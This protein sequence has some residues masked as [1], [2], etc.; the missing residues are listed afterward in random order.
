MARITDLPNEVLV[1]ISNV[2]D[3]DDVDVW[4]LFEVRLMHVYVAQTTDLSSFARTCWRIYD[5]INH[6]LY[7]SS[8][9][10]DDT[11]CLFWAARNG[12][13]GTLRHALDAGADPNA[14]YCFKPRWC[15][16]GLI[17]TT[18]LHLAA[19]FGHVTIVEA[20]LDAGANIDTEGQR[21]CEPCDEPMKARWDKPFLWTPIQ[22]AIC[23]KQVDAWAV[24][25]TRG[26]SWPV[27][28]KT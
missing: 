11:Y 19:T 22:A 3:S 26:A 14:V 16:D 24:L 25:L 9:M 8:I 13:I 23:N 2:L 27:L 12:E 4:I 15:F 20:L 21:P 28:R 6:S 1:M 17:Q 7:R 10:K 5:V 18:A